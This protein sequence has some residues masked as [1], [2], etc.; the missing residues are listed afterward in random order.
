[1]GNGGYGVDATLPGVLTTRGETIY[2]N[3]SGGVNVGGG[4]TWNESY[5]NCAGWPKIDTSGLP[6]VVLH[7]TTGDAQP[8]DCSIYG[9][10]VLILPN[11]DHVAF[12]CPIAGDASLTSVA[13]DRLPGELG[14]NYTFVSG[15]EAQVKPSLEGIIT[16][17]FVIPPAVSDSTLIIMHWDGS[18]WV[19]RGGI[20]TK[21]QFFEITSAEA[22]IFVLVSQ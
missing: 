7:V 19:D 5:A 8:L 6:W 10:T 21:D 12:P 22:G 20:E 18:Q 17:D 1:V 3:A 11:W 2:N 9:G 16:V 4:G 13:A 15:L 14:E